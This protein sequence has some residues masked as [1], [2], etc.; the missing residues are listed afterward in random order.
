MRFEARSQRPPGAHEAGRPGVGSNAAAAA[1]A[2]VIALAAVSALHALRRELE[3]ASHRLSEYATGP[4]GWLM[5]LAFAAVATGVWLLRRALPASDALRPVRTLLTVAASGFVLS[6]V[7]PTDPAQ[8][9]AV[10]ETVH[11]VASTGAL[12]ALTTAALWTVTVGARALG[13]HGARG[14]AG[15]STAVAA[16]GLLISPLVHDSPWTGA[17]QRLCYLALTVWLLLACRAVTGV[18]RTGTHHP[19]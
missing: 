16:L 1:A 3:P 10:G 14:P 13:W 11:S 7:V 19:D 18:G 12:V 17:V 4:W 9:D 5:T 2:T 8:P 15:A 6:A